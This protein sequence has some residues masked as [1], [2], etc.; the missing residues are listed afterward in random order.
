MSRVVDDLEAKRLRQVLGHY[1]TGVTVV[2]AMS[3]EGEPVG[4]AI[5][6][7]TSI[8]LDPPLVGFFPETKSS[9][10]PKI[11]A[12]GSFCVNILGAAQE[13]E[14]RAFATRGA[15]RFNGVTWEPAGSGAPRLKGVVAWIDCDIESVT[16]AGDHY[17]VLGRVR[18]LDVSSSSLPLV[19]FRG[20]YGQFSP[21]SLVAAHEPDLVRALRYAGLARD[22]MEKIA[23]DLGLEVTAAAA[24][25]SNLVVVASAGPPASSSAPPLVGRRIPMIPPLGGQYMAWEGDAAVA[26][27]LANSPSSLSVDEHA[28]YRT[29]LARIRRR[30]WLLYP[31]DTGFAEV[32]DLVQQSFYEDPD[33]EAQ[34]RLRDAIRDLP[35]G[36]DTL[37]VEPGETYS[38]SRVI[39]PIPADDGKIALALNAHVTAELCTYD[40]IMKI[41]DRL[42]TAAARL[43]HQAGPVE[44]A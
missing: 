31:A 14:C 17:V 19:F 44:H 6:S 35:I 8:S 15:D 24:V 21:R 41:R 16:E 22:E 29:A 12:A 28:A 33:G 11:R 20:G 36:F 3:N 27:W 18:S 32:D 4:M 42:R 43:G 37:D 34:I 38:V 2:T 26:E 7:F 40:T 1:P 30:G 5:G 10:F 39:V 9:T 23:A 13:A 25:G